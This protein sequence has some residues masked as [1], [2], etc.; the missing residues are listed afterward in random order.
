MLCTYK[1]YTTLMYNGSPTAL[2]RAGTHGL[3]EQQDAEARQRK[4]YYARVHRE[5][6]VDHQQRPTRHRCDHPASAL[7]Q[8]VYDEAVEMERRTFERAQRLRR[9][10]FRELTR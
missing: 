5:G 4:H 3:L 6:R 1:R 2:A 9:R 7:A 10:P 8:L